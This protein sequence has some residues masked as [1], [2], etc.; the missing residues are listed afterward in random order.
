M[1]LPHR[2][3]RACVTALL[4]GDITYTPDPLEASPDG[5][6]LICCAQ[7]RTDVVLDM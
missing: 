5:Q 4:S 3:C 7:P 1:Q 6:A 2:G